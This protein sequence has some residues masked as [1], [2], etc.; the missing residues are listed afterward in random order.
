MRSGLALLDGSS[1]LIAVYTD[2]ALVD[3]PKD[4]PSLLHA[5]S[6]NQVVREKVLHMSVVY[7]AY[8]TTMYVSLSPY[9]AKAF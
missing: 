4:L 2:A 1:L 7:E 8:T 3:G 6:T 9:R 5:N